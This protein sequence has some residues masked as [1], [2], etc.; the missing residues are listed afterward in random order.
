MSLTA[1]SGRRDRHGDDG[2]HH[3]RTAPNSTEAF[4]TDFHRMSGG[5][6]MA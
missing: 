6:M 1:C 3:F 4:Q 2:A 5:Q